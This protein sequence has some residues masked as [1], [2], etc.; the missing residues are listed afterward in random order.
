MRV[1]IDQFAANVA[2][3]SGQAGYSFDPTSILAIVAVIVQVIGMLKDC[4][5]TTVR[6]IQRLRTPSALDRLRLRDAVKKAG[7]KAKLRDPGIAALLDEAKEMNASQL[8]AMMKE[9]P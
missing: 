7:I 6:A 3:R 1:E 8:I 4:K 5:L 2:K 9:V